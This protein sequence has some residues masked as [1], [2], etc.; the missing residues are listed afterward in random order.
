MR[1]DGVAFDVARDRVLVQLGAQSQQQAQGGA[2]GG[3]P[4]K[5]VGPAVAAA[6]VA[7]P[8]TAIEPQMLEEGKI[9]HSV[10][11]TYYASLNPP[12]ILD[13]TIVEIVASLG[14]G[15]QFYTRLYNRL[16]EEIIE[17]LR[18]RPDILDAG[19]L[20]IYEIKSFQSR[21][22]AIGE[23][24]GYIAI[25]EE[26]KIPGLELSLGSPSN[27]G[28]NSFSPAPGGWCVW[29]CPLPGAIIYRMVRPPENPRMAQELLEHEA[30]EL[31]WTEQMG[32]EGWTA[33]AAIAA[34]ADWEALFGILRRG[35][36]VAGRAVLEALRSG[37]GS[38]AP[39]SVQSAAR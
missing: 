28:A 16:P 7:A 6:G 37:A 26:M 10:V 3:V 39:Q 20:Q 23:A 36:A 30:Q 29:A 33:I 17:V 11:G 38:S 31:S 4:G 1:Q 21:G 2:E 25:L 15:T 22:K 24:V 9:C 8:A 19:K 18:V 14:L 34:A 27:A 32:V 35:G 13:K 12:T 5:V